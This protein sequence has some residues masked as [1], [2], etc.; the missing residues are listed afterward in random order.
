MNVTRTT[1]YVTPTIPQDKADLQAPRTLPEDPPKS[2]VFSPSASDSK[3]EST[4]ISS[5]Q[6]TYDQGA[7]SRRVSKPRLV[8]GTRD[9]RISSNRR[10]VPG[11]PLSAG[12]VAQ[13][14]TTTP[15]ALKKSEKKKKGGVFRLFSKL[16]CCGVPEDANAIDL[17]EQAVPTRKPSKLVPTQA[18]QTTLNNKPSISAAE[19]STTGSRDVN[20][21]KIGGPPYSSLKSAG[22]PIIQEQQQPT[23][24]KATP[25]YQP[26][27]IVSDEDQ[28][29]TQATPVITQEL[30]VPPTDAQSHE[31]Q[32]DTVQQ[33]NPVSQGASVIVVPPMPKVPASSEQQN[34]MN[35]Q[36]PLQEA[37]DSDTEMVDAPPIEPISDKSEKSVEP[38]E[39]EISPAL[40]PPPPIVPRAETTSPGHDRNSS[41]NVPVLNDQHKWLLPPM[42]PE[43]RGKKCLVLDLD[44]TLVHSSF[45][46]GTKVL[47]PLIMRLTIVDTPSS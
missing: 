44:E 13:S 18:R 16:N 24:S 19:S 36:T 23:T 47:S 12:A 8:G 42:K 1:E 43:F 17:D 40:P 46:V 30:T 45:K 41:N 29:S 9:G 21:E 35:D 4:T 20:D 34:V 33:A 7:R 15:L 32:M 2:S 39:A 22:E 38:N 14:T 6:P 37:G 3:L 27:S 5:T 10:S 25:I 11:Q 26:T 28:N 31:M